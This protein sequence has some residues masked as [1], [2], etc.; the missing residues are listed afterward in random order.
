MPIT[1]FE[2]KALVFNNGVVDV[3]Q[4][5]VSV[6]DEN[7]IA[8]ITPGEVSIDELTII[9]NADNEL[10]V[11]FDNDTIYRDPSDGFIKA[12]S[13]GGSSYT[14]GDGISIS[15]D[16]IALDQSWLGDYGHVKNADSARNA[17]SAQ[18]ADKIDGHY[19][20]DITDL[21]DEK[22][23]KLI[24][25]ANITITSEGII[26]AS[27]GGGSSYEA[28]D[29]ID[30]SSDVISIDQ[31]WAYENLRVYRAQEASDASNAS[32][33]SGHSWQEISTELDG[34][35]RTLVA[36]E[37]ITISGN[38]ISSTA[39][40]EYDTPFIR[41]VYYDYMDD[42]STYWYNFTLS[43]PQ[44][45]ATGE[46]HFMNYVDE[47]IHS[48]NEDNSMTHYGRYPLV[49]LISKVSRD[50]NGELPDVFNGIS[51]YFIDSAKAEFVRSATSPMGVH[52]SVYNVTM[53]SSIG[54]FVINMEIYWNDDT[55]AIMTSSTWEITEA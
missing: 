22:Q 24:A 9:K 55:P 6:V 38:L 13:S 41:A 51:Q 30:I 26:S 27:G 54:R 33:L 31:N 10:E 25:G 46:R 28:G 19:Y 2:G 1:Q 12:R 11:P 20:S 7:K 53:S 18:D 43:N 29:G 37:G 36:G 5:G 45:W 44:E 14:A 50:I 48:T 23:D 17:R 32:K 52:Y 34:K 42:P 47:L 3:Q 16:E 40:P 8:H 39:V 49:V 4:D 35:Q 15:N 21:I